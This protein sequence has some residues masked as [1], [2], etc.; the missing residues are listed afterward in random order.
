V[1]NNVFLADGGVTTRTKPIAPPPPISYND[2]V[3][4]PYAPGAT[5]LPAGSPTP[6][7]PAPGPDTGGG[8]GSGGGGGGDAT[9]PPPEID[10]A[11]VYFGQY[12][13]PADLI[14]QIEALGKQYGTTNPDVFYNSALNAV[15]GSQWFATT[16]PG[17]A[18]GVRAGLFADETGYRGYVNDLN[19]IYQQY[20]GRSVSGDETSAALSSG[21][22]PS[23]IGRQFQGDAIARTN[24]PEWAYVSGAFDETGALTDAEKTALGREQAGVDT[25]LGQLVQKRVQLAM[26][27]ASALFGGTL[28]TPSLSLTN[29]RLSAPS[30]GGSTTPDIAA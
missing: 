28:A 19:S 2:P 18:A 8:G 11:K 22:A 16:Y 26:G 14:A 25:P 7:G 24:A 1:P 5:P 12:N 4:S 21:Y 10:W 6:Y 3:Q 17:F 29:G 15:R 9:S 27:R 13:L 23:L 30:L 20:L